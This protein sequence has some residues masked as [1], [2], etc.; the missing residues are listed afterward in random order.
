MDDK[1]L[2][3]GMVVYYTTHAVFPLRPVC[4]HIIDP[5]ILIL[6]LCVCA[7]VQVCVCVQCSN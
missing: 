3:E 4:K 1:H 6:I 5:P 2:W 7:Y